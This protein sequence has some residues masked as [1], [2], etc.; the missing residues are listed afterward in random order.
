M[1]KWMDGYLE[2]LELNRLENLTGG[3][4]ERIDLQHSLGKLTARERIDRLVDA[5]TFDEIGSLVRDNRPPYDGKARPSPAE[6]V[7]MGFGKVNGRPVMLFSMDFTVMS[8]SLG[9]QAAWKLADLTVMA[10]K[11]RTA[12]DRHDRLCR[13]ATEPPRWKQRFERSGQVHEEHESLF[14]HHPQNRAPPRS[15]HRNDGGDSRPLGFPDHQSRAPDSCGSAE[16]S[17]RKLQARPSST[18]KRA[19]SAT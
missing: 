3:G 13:R 10:A 6:G 2:K 14:R 15:L 1:G 18:W 19:A 8:G 9:D 16:K 5:G 4:N 12:P 7:I 11:R 17:N